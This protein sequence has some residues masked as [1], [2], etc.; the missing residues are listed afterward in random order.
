MATKVNQDTLGR[1]LVQ[2]FV[3][4]MDGN[5][6]AKMKDKRLYKVRSMEEDKDVY[7]RLVKDL[8][9]G[10]SATIFKGYFRDENALKPIAIKR[11]DSEEFKGFEDEFQRLLD[12][13][14]R[15]LTE[16]KPFKNFVTEYYG[17]FFY[18]PKKEHWLAMEFCDGA[19]IFDLAPYFY[20]NTDKPTKFSKVL[21]TF[22]NINTDRRKSKVRNRSKVMLGK[23]FTN[24]T[25]QVPTNKPKVLNF[26]AIAAVAAGAL[27]G[28]EVI[29]KAG[30]IHGDIKSGNILL[31]YPGIVKI[32]DFGLTSKVKGEA[33]PDYHALGTL[34]YMS[35][36]VMLKS[37]AYDHGK[38]NPERY[39]YDYKTD[40]WALGIII[41]ELVL[42]RTPMSDMRRANEDE[43]AFFI[44]NMCK[45]KPEHKG[46]GLHMFFYLRQYHQDFMQDKWLTVTELDLICRRV[47]E[48]KTNKKHLLKL[49]GRP[50]MFNKRP[51]PSLEVQKPI[52][53]KL[54]T[55]NKCLDF[56]AQCLYIR[57][58]WRP[59]A[60]QLQEH[61]F[62]KAQCRESRKLD[63]KI[64]ALAAMQKKWG[65]RKK[66]WRRFPAPLTVREIFK[67]LEKHRRKVK[68]ELFSIEEED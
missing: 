27:R 37:L 55:I 65:E 26:K 58:K 49:L 61:T 14:K 22:N 63:S 21:P 8:A 52:I 36:E 33:N 19:S 28:L 54:F 12:R 32:C 10:A 6:R 47:P 40:V 31:C 66:V 56:V 51:I 64:D 44:A 50:Q 46:S 4:L 43:F 39:K 25:S 60:V 30:F 59:S 48:L 1:F 3:P 13:E 38:A 2:E 23:N 11:I 34:D 7:F 24:L 41:L 45:N 29:H 42:G 16:L 53:S 15:A 35:P 68:K 18:Q 9:G 67:V 20:T 62:V 17:S 5:E 57:Y